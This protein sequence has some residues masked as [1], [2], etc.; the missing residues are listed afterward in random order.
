MPKD[1]FRIDHE[2]EARELREAKQKKTASK[3][4]ESAPENGS[5]SSKSEDSKAKMAKTPRKKETES[6]EV[7]LRQFSNFFISGMMAANCRPRESDDSKPSPPKECGGCWQKA[8]SGIKLFFCSRCRKES[9]SSKACQ[10]YHYHE[11][12][13]FCNDNPKVLELNLMKPVEEC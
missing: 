5:A 8:D 9:Y 2:R 13:P 6:E 7:M 10:C 1:I 11:H 3:T 4:S 12:K